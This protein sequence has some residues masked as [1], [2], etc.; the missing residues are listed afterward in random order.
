M[1]ACYLH[2][3]FKFLHLTQLIALLHPDMMPPLSLELCKHERPLTN[4]VQIISVGAVHTL[5]IFDN[6]DFFAHK[7]HRQG[8]KQKWM[9]LLPFPLVLRLNRLCASASDS[10]KPM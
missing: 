2:A 4:M 7:I 10:A 9:H 6:A 1:E 5:P 8:Q 3:I